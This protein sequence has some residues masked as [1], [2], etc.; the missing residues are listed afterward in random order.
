SGTSTAYGPAQLTVSTLDDFYKRHPD[1]FSE[2]EKDYI[3]RFSAQ[4]HKMMHADKN[5]PV[6]GYGGTGILNSKPDQRLYGIVVRKML[7]QMVKDNGGSLDK[8]V[9]RWR[10]NDTD[11][12]YFAKVLAA[13][14]EA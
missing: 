13:Y 11:H 2:Q 14:K 5:D 4:G 12:K 10:G 1:L 7:Q 3:H 9:K 8:T 6:F